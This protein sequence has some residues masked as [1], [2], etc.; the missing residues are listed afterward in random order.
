MPL[1]ICNSKPGTVSEEAK[2]KIANDVTHIHCE[3]TDAPATFVHVFFFENGPQPPL[4][5]KTAMI[6]GQIRAGRT[7][8]QKADIRDQ[9]AAAL[10]SH[11]GLSADGRGGQLSIEPAAGGECP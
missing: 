2:S 5:D 7:D 1:Y 3:V 8:S 11:T 6:Y 4:G 10:A 9:M